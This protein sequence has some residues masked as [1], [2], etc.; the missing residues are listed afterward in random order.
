MA[1]RPDP[2]NRFGEL[3]YTMTKNRWRITLI[4]LIT[5]GLITIG[6]IVAMIM[7]THIASEWKEIL[8]LLLGAFLGNYNKVSDFWFSNHENDR[9]L[10][11]KM[12]EED[13]AGQLEEVIIP[14]TSVKK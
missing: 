4:N 2:H 14:E 5:F 11:Q 13:G 8:L 12:D 1:T 10:A 7:G 6:I 9:L 3:L